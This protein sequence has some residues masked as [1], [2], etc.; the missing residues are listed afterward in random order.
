MNKFILLLGLCTAAFVIPLSAAEPSPWDSWRTA[1]SCFEKGESFRDKGDYLQA[2]KSFEDALASYQ[3]VKKARPDWN[4]RV[5]A[6]RIERCRTECSKM[7]RLLGKN[8]PVIQE[9]GVPLPTIAEPVLPQ[10]AGDSVELRNTKTQLQQAALELRELRRKD[11]QSRKFET[12]IANLLRDLRVAKEEYALLQRRCKT[13]EDKLNNPDSGSEQFR[14]QL[15]EANMRYERL[16]KQFDS[17]SLRMRSLEESSRNQSGLRTVAENAVVK[18]RNE[19]AKLNQ[20]IEE[21]RKNIAD[22]NQKIKLL[23][24]DLKNSGKGYQQ[25]SE[26]QD[27]LLLLN[28]IGF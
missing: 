6:I 15:I 11:E 10:T 23:E 26:K 13:L 16:K 3:A 7:R 4:Q 25:S 12:E 8:A 9:P 28:I 2:L 17:V 24:I 5:I 20:Q 19:N 14:N 21:F 27:I 1:Y 22:S 18:L